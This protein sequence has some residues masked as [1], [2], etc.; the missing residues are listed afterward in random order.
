MGELVKL[1]VGRELKGRLLPG[2]VKI[3]DPR[4]DDKE[5]GRRRLFSVNVVMKFNTKPLNFV[6]K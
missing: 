6:K 3:K 2:D 5:D 4:F 1:K